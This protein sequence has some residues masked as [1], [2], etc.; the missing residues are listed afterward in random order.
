MR[1]VLRQIWHRQV[2]EHRLWTKTRKLDLL[3]CIQQVMCPVKATAE[4]HVAAA[5]IHVKGVAGRELGI[6]VAWK[7]P[8]QLD[9]MLSRPG[10]VPNLLEVMVAEGGH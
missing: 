3:G 1:S 2:Q 4:A 8:A 9:K 5:L 7:S 6:V 10:P